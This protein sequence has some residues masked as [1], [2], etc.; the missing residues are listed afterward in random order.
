MALS[1]RLPNRIETEQSCELRTLRRRLVSPEVTHFSTLI[2][3]RYRAETFLAKLFTDDARAFSRGSPSL[4]HLDSARRV[5]R[6]LDISRPSPKREAA[7]DRRTE[8]GLRKMNTRGTEQVER[9][10]R[11]VGVRVWRR[12]VALA[13][14]RCVRASVQSRYV[15]NCQRGRE[16]EL[17][18]KKQGKRKNISRRITQT[19][20]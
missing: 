11:V 18:K 3:R 20:N 12:V 13:R 14:N 7:K 5:R 9:A 16:N 8:E 10:N 2:V 4:R 19:A 1:R 15:G 17:T 6:N